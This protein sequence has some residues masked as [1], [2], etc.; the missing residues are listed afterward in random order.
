MRR[1]TLFLPLLGLLYLFL[2]SIGLIGASFK[3]FGNDMAHQIFAFTSNPLC[4]LFIGIL[5]TSLVQSSSVT[6]SIVVGMVAGGT[7]GIEQ[8]VP[9]V[10]GANIGTSVTNML[11]SMGHISRGRE[12]R[13]AFS[14]ALVHDFFNVLSVLILFPLQCATGFLSTASM[15]LSGLFT[16]GA[17]L[18]FQSPIKEIIDPVVHLIQ[19]I[20][21]RVVAKPQFQA[22]LMLALA[23]LML[24]LA[25]KYMTKLLRGV[26]MEKASGFFQQTLFR[27]PALAFV[28]GMVLTAAVQSSSI[29]TS[30]VIPLA[31]AGILT[32]RQIYPYTLGANVGTTITALLASLAA[33]Q[34]FDV[35]VAVAISHLLFNI[36]GIAVIVPFRRIREIP[37][38]LAEW[39]ADTAVVHRWFPPVYILIFFFAVPMALIYLTR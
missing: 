15:W 2:V 32:I 24:F 31:G 8:A 17:D 5:T 29:T 14:A 7:L 33:T 16:G 30:L 23:G 10:M 20:L 4:G 35:A 1:V 3:L 37:I 11:V 18:K 39:M 36:C 38:H 27:T 9:I 22:L 26:V 34:H 13:R 6:T 25:L 12:F 19:G 28:V 21:G